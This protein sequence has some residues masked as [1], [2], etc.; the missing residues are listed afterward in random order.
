VITG[1]HVILYS[2][3]AEADRA[4]FRDV[5][6]YPSVDAGHGWLIFALPPAEIAVHPAS[7]GGRAELYLLCDD[8][9]VTVT[10]LQASGIEIA[11]PIN[12]QGWGLLTAITLP[13]GVELGL[14]Q[15][16]HPT[17]TQPS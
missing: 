10:T 15:P 5:L 11:R 13:G 16:R 12:D 4:F 8:V 3:D 2:T 1:A 14:Y 6:E 7:E 17:A 9:A